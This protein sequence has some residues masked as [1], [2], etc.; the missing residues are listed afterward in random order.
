[1]P[2]C[3]TKRVEALWPAPEHGTAQLSQLSTQVKLLSSLHRFRSMADE[4]PV[5]E[6]AGMLHELDG[7]RGVACR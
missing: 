1:M 6:V 5:N 7:K 4:D 2:S 3:E